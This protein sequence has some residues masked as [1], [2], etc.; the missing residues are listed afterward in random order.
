VYVEDGPGSCYWL[1]LVQFLL[2]FIKW[3]NSS[4]NFNKRCI[5]CC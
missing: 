3:Q 1:Q 2:Y 4:H 5:P